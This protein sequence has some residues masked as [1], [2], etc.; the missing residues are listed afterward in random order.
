MEKIRI[1]I[2][3][4]S[5]KKSGGAYQEYL[6]TLNNI[7]K[8]VSKFQNIDFLF[9]CTSR[10]L[11]LSLEQQNINFLY[12]N[13]NIFERFICY[14]RNFGPFVRRIKKYFFFENKF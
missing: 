5:R 9:I 14:L 4:D 1:G 10:K 13:L 11:D 8:E 2:F 12:F 7:K 6:Y 3:I